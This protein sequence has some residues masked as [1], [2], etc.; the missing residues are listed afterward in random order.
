MYRKALRRGRAWALAAAGLLTLAG[1]QAAP[2]KLT[3]DRGKPVLLRDDA[4]RVA[5]IS[6]FAADTALALGLRPVASTFLV[7]GREPEY[8]LGCTASAAKLGQRAA[9]N[10]ELLAQS[11]PDLVVAI[12]RYTEANAAKLEQVAPYMA[13]NLENYADSDRSIRLLGEA[14]GKPAAAQRLNDDFRGASRELAARAAGRQRPSYL[15]LWGSGDAP[16]AFY[17]EHMTS[18]IVNGV[19]AVNA[20]GANPTP[21]VAD[22]TAFEMSVEAMLAADPDL[23]F[24]YDYGPNRRFE[25][26]PLW[27]RLKAVKNRRVV[28]VKDHW[29]ESHG[30]VARQVVLREAAH[31]LHPAVFAPADVRA[32]ATT[33]IPRCP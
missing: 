8:L 33:M 30:P 31:A 14:L 29:I 4:K 17:N 26:N 24:V 22:N 18:A 5:A 21:A 11:R 13:L 32:I 28:Y 2:H 3:D 9:P 25:R 20:A 10:L 16:W 1:V 15:F 27:A 6:Y 23:I 12:R 19:G 7:K